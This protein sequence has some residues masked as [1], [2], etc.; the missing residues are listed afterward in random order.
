MLLSL[1]YDG[2]S[3]RVYVKNSEE[4]VMEFKDEV[5]AGDGAFKALVP[6]KGVLCASISAHLLRVIEDSGIGTH[7]VNYDGLRSIT[8]RK[9]KMV[10][11]EVIVR[12]Y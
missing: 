10:P 1:I 2:K 11:V 3:K 4:I 9:L 7:F 12:N 5:T 8:A 6:G